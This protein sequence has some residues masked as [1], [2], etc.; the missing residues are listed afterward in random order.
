VQVEV[1]DRLTR[2]SPSVD[3]QIEGLRLVLHLELTAKADA[4][5]PEVCELFGFELSQ[6]DEVPARDD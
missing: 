4:E 3:A 5:Q 6:L 2:G 1:V